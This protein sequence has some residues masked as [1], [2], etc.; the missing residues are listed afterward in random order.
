[1]KNFIALFLILMCSFS[2]AQKEREVV[3]NED[4]NL[5]EATYFHDNGVVSQIGTYTKDGKLHGEW[6]TFCEN[7]KKLISATYKNGKKVGKWFYWKG[8]VLTEVD[9]DNNKIANVIEWT[10]KE[11]IATRN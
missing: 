2:F 3:L 11:L 5:I 7:G 9:Y 4:T 8:D 10:N 1:M 6:T